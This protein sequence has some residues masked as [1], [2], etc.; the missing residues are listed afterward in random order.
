MWRMFRET[1]SI[2]LGIKPEL[3]RFFLPGEEVR[4]GGIPYVVLS[5]SLWQTRFSGDP[6]IVGKSIELARHS[7]TV[8]GVAPAGFI[9]AMPG[10]REDHSLLWTRQDLC[11]F[12][13]W[14]DYD[15]EDC[16]AWRCAWSER[17]IGE[18]TI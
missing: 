9:N 1:F 4:E 10:A 2:C 3:G 15:L 7:V 14:Q 17:S 18:R 5:H 12:P 16:R 6:A 8:I 11:G 13:R